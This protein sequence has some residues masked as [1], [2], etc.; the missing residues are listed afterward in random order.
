MLESLANLDHGA[1]NL[2]AY[3]EQFSGDLQEFSLA[4]RMSLINKC[5]SPLSY[6][7]IVGSLEAAD[8]E[9]AGRASGML[10]TLKTMSPTALFATL[11]LLRRGKGMSFKHCLEMEYTLAKNFM[12]HVP[13]LKE[14]I[15]AK[16]VRKEKAGQWRPASFTDVSENSIESLFAPEPTDLDRLEFLNDTD[17]DQ[18]PHC[19]NALPSRQRIKQMV[20]ENRNLAS[21]KELIE[22]ICSAHH[23]KQGLRA[24][25]ERV[26]K[27]HVRSR[28]E[29]E[30][31]G[32]MAVSSLTWVD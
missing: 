20:L 6:R 21:C 9:D 15:T 5:F 4:D 29:L 23:Q 2:S 19:D 25:L 30:K 17:Y 18:Y 13:D 14:G 7:N 28:E 8:K 10:D 22:S 16:L 1:E 27:E 11:A 3:L 26:M 24:K 32:R 12:R 31:S